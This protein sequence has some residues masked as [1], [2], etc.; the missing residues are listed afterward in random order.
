[1]KYLAFVCVVLLLAAC[2]KYK[3]PEA[4]F[5]FQAL[6]SINGGIQFTNCSVDATSYLW[7]FGN[8]ASS[9]EESPM[10]LFELNFPLEVKLIVSND[11]GTDT[12]IQYITND[13]LQL[14]PISDFSYQLTGHEYTFAKFTNLS[15]NA[16]TFSWDFGDG[17]T[18]FD[19][20]P[21][22][23]YENWG[24]Y[25]V[26]LKA[27]LENE[28]SE[29]SMK[30]LVIDTINLY[31]GFYHTVN[32][33][34][35]KEVHFFN[36][37]QNGKNFNWDFGDG[38]T[39]TEKAPV[40]EYT[41]SGRYTVSLKASN[42]FNSQ[43]IKDEIAIVEIQYIVEAKFEFQIDADNPLLVHYTNQSTNAT[44]YTWL[45]SDGTESHEENPSHEFQSDEELASGFAQLI[46]ENE[47]G[48]YDNVM[49]CIVSGCGLVGKPNVYIYPTKPIRLQLY[50]EFPLGGQVASSVPEYGDGW[51]VFV[52]PGGMIDRRYDYLFYESNQVS[53]FQKQQ[54]WCVSKSNLKAFFQSNMALYKFNE[55]EITDFVKY[56]IPRLNYSEY[57]NIYP[58]TNNIIDQ[59]ITLKFSE[60]PD[61]IIRLFYGI[62]P[63]DEFKALPAPSIP[64]FNREGF[65]VTEWGVYQY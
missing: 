27:N 5:D 32:E 14:K 16:N 9:T 39:S 13:Q 47:N 52:E 44:S 31:P 53:N 54:G 45:F 37:T 1:M 26:T 22:H 21:V 38:S 41:N 40:H 11:Y 2:S 36:T 3:H 62:F 20:N 43:T 30:V 49:H 8:G 7:D 50:I 56:W 60:E 59:A 65:V 12:L 34:N 48:G 33:N 63:S 19:E 15:V 17:S 57:F 61:N 25:N 6:D 42:E 46:A 29:K 24:E 51:N 64:E 18:S 4:C 10:H 23:P 35:W 55:Q 28:E 58:Q